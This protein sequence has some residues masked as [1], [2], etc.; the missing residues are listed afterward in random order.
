MASFEDAA[1][2]LSSV[3][4][5]GLSSVS[6]LAQQQLSIERRIAELEE[7]VSDA[8]KEL[9]EVSEELLPSAMAEYGISE[10]KLSDGSE[11][12]VGKFYSA[13]ISKARSDEAFEWLNDKGFGDLIKNQVSTKF[14]RGQEKQAEQF[15][16][17][18]VSRGMAVNTR[19]WVEP[20]TLKAFVKDQTEQGKEL[21]SELF[22]LYIGNKAKIKKVKDYGI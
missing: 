13:T 4:E 15:A 3:D 8:K 17:E 20:M 22:G 5:T 1:A 19:K 9:R 16:Q 21:P 7:M 12:T 11:I 10:L 18:L 2:T 6:K 14:V